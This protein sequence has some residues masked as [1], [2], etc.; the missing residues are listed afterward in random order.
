MAHDVTG[1]NNMSFNQG[2]H[3]KQMRH[4]LAANGFIYKKCA[5]SWQDMSVIATVFV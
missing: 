2:S 4:F 5:I 1:A 3:A